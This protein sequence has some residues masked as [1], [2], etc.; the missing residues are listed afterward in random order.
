MPLDLNLETLKGE[1][2]DYLAASEFAVF[3][4]HAGGFDNMNVPRP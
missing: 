4:S 1:M 3:R 2:L